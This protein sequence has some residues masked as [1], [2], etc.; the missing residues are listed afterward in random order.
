MPIVAAGG[1]GTHAQAARCIAAGAGAVRCGTVFV[2]AA[3]S[4]ARDAYRQALIDAT[5][6]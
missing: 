5:P 2:A 3:E 6:S 4:G 1:I